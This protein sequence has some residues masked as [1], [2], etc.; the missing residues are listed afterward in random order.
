MQKQKSYPAKTMLTISMGFLVI[1]LLADWQPALIISLAIGLIGVFSTFLS[2]KIEW[3]WMKLAW[4]LSLIVPNILLSVIFF[5]ILF[6]MAM[7]S[8]LFGK[9]DPL[10]LK[11]GRESM[12]RDVEGKFDRTSFEEM[13]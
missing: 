11:R 1:Y 7:L 2:E 9:K 6:P 13:W 10:M 4:V 12:F 3:A 5:L 8:R